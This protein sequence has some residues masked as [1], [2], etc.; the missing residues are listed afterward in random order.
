MTKEDLMRLHNLLG[1]L[2][3]VTIMN[4]IAERISPEVVLS[5]REIQAVIEEIVRVYPS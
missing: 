4:I 3:G 1:E 2:E 5:I